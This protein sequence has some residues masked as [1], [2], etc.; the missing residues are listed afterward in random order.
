MTFV[1]LG[2]LVEISKG[3][4][5]NGKKP[6][7]CTTN[8][9]ILLNVSTKPMSLWLFYHYYTGNNEWQDTSLFDIHNK[10]SC[11]GDD[12]HYHVEEGNYGFN[13]KP[14]LPDAEK[15]ALGALRDY[16]GL[17]NNSKVFK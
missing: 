4:T 1:A 15:D 8:Y 16:V 17:L 5:A 3:S 6:E 10:S 13:A 11:H 9:V 7:R 12:Q 2:W 14:E